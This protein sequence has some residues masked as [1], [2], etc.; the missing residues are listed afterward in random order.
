M[1]G[2]LFE[3]RPGMGFGNLIIFFEAFQTAPHDAADGFVMGFFK[4]S[5]VGLSLGRLQKSRLTRGRAQRM[6]HQRSQIER[7]DQPFQGNRKHQDDP[8]ALI[9]FL[10]ARSVER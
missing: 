8:A 10:Q 9:D 6:L 7:H 5:E 2:V 3:F 4:F 1:H